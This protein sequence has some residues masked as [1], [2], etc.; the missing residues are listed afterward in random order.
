[1]QG[2]HASVGAP[3]RTARLAYVD[4]VKALVVAGVIVVH[5]G[6]T[7]GLVGDWAYQEVPVPPTALPLA[8]ALGLSATAG[9][10]VLFL[11]AGLFTPAALAAKGRRR[12]LAGRIRRLGVPLVVYLLLIM[13]ALNF[14][15]AWVE[16][17][18]AIAGWRRMLARLQGFDLGP[19]WF[20][21]ALSL[22]T[23]AYA[24][25]TAVRTNSGTTVIR[26]RDLT[27][28]ALLAGLAMFGVR[29]LQPITDPAPLNFGIWPQHLAFFALGLLGARNGWVER[30]P[31]AALRGAKAMMLVALAPL[32]PLV[33]LET[34]TVAGLAGG[35]RWE[36]LL[37]SLGQALFTIGLTIWLFRQFQ[38]LTS[39]SWSSF[40][41]ASFETY[42][43]QSPVVVLM[44]IAFRPVALPAP[45]KAV[46]LSVVAVPVCFTIGAAF[47]R[48]SGRRLI[49][50]LL[51]WDLSATPGGGQRGARD[52]RA[53][54]SALVLRTPSVRG[55]L[56][57]AA[58]RT[59]VQ[60]RQ[61][62]YS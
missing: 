6:M 27:L 34:P 13:P 57:P 31:R 18:S 12:F 43:V 29:L 48:W 44:G 23:V 54:A 7:Y 56:T 62:R 16:S 52:A 59:I 15:G 53:D 19:A 51:R 10:G 22:F 3:A 47:H 21:L 26:F 41:A 45:L 32:G 39:A 17:G 8:V 40:T 42:L 20:L 2:S 33:L 25:W 9:M 55:S 11:L 1:M 5:A 50:S 14:G 37:L 46:L 60:D 58:G 28:I 30:V 35:W 4:V 24:L 49:P 61:H 38:R 36:S